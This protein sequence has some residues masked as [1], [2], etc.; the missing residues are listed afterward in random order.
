MR[1]YKGENFAL[2]APSVCLR[3]LT[4]LP[5]R[6]IFVKFDVVD[7]YTTLSRN[8]KSDKNIGHFTWRRT[9][10]LITVRNILYLDNN[11]MFRL[12][13]CTKK[14]L[15]FTVTWANSRKR[16]HF[17]FFKKLMFLYCSQWRTYLTNTH[18][19]LLHFY[20]ENVYAN[21]LQCYVILT[22]P[23]FFLLLT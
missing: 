22:L 12:H 6:R 13:G 15:Q 5:I 18:R 1:L 8:P 9:S 19:A 10:V 21:V 16:R 7:F 2:T 3:I 14:I 4:R 11:A 20:G 23:V 17:C